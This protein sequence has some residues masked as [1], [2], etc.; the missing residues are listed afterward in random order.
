MT[1]FSE[2]ELLLHRYEQVKNQINEACISSN[3]NLNEINLIVVSKFQPETKIRWL[4]EAGHREFAE[5]RA[6]EMEVK[7]KPLLATYP[8]VK[9]HFI[10]QIQSRKIKLIVQYSHMIHSLDRIE[11]AEKIALECSKQHKY[12]ACLIQI[13]TGLESQKGGVDPGLFSAFFQ[14]C[15]LISGLTITGIMCIPPAY[16]QPTP[17]FR[18]MQTLKNDYQLD[19]L[20]MGMSNDYIEAITYGA[21]MLRIGTKIMGER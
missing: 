6:E 8:D 15:K 3:R 10:G 4:L 14:Q 20:S 21:T 1:D 17:H 16:Q 7:W 11:I 18:L 2:K 12:P 5:S 13:N 9:L 19:E